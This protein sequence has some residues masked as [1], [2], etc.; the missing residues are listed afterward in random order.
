M[1]FF[2]AAITFCGNFHA[3]RLIRDQPFTKSI[4]YLLKLLT[5][6]SIILLAGFL[7]RALRVAAEFS[8]WIDKHCPPF[9]IRDGHVET[10]VAQPYTSGDENFLFVLDTTGK[11][12]KPDARAMRGLL[13]TSNSFVVWAMA[14]NTPGT[15]VRSQAQSLR[16]FPD[17]VVDGEYL[18]R[19]IHSFLLV[20]LPISLLAMVLIA[21]LMCLLQAYFFSVVASLLERNLPSGLRLDQLLNIAIH[22]V[23]PAAIITTAYSFMRLEGLDLWLVYL[24]AY[25]VF[26]IGA[27][28]ACRE[29]PMIRGS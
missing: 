19:L 21:L 5:V 10:A 22:A 24:V 9:A 11:V 27:S 8:K 15:A 4:K 6:L 7:P 17:G 3:Y 25:G 28:N 29:K 2:K 23:T 26:V 14:T 1:S 13:F 12:T 20:A 16:G 18:R